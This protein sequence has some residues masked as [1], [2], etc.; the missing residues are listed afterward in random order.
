LNNINARKIFAKSK[1]FLWERAQEFLFKKYGEKINILDN[2][3]SGLKQPVYEMIA[4]QQSNRDVVPEQVKPENRE[5]YRFFLSDT[6]ELDGR[7]NFVIRFREVNYKNPDR[8]RKYNGAI[9]VDT[10]T[11]GIKRLKISVKTKTTES[12]P[13]PGYFIITNGSWLMKP[14]S[15]KW[16]KWR[17]MIKT[18]KTKRIKKVLEPTPS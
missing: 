11:Y 7:K 8:K 3:I 14:P 16:E 4:L 9:Y 13:V 6:I 1:L 2:R 10:E 18:V 12:S 15:L 5:L 17:W